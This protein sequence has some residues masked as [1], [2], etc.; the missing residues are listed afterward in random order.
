M[1]VKILDLS[2][3]N[4]NDES[5]IQTI[6]NLATI[7]Y[8]NDKAKNPEKLFTLLIE[9]GHESVLEFIRFPYITPTG[10]LKGYTIEESWR[11]QR[12]LLTYERWPHTNIDTVTEIHK[13]A[14]VTLR[15]KVPIFVDR[16]LV[17]H[18]QDSRI[19]LSRRYT[20]PEKVEFEYYYPYEDKVYREE[21]WNQDYQR[22][23]HKGNRPEIARITQPLATYTEYYVMRHFVG[24][25]NLYVERLSVYAQKETYELIKQEVELIIKEQPQFLGLLFYDV[26]NKS[27]ISLEKLLTSDLETDKV[28][29]DYG[30]K[31]YYAVF[32]TTKRC[33]VGKQL[34]PIESCNLHP[35]FKLYVD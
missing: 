25:R 16:Q 33:F 22:M 13:Q 35:T 18:R 24:A 15:V 32:D 29:L 2:K 1:E 34:K 9:K 20:K 26:R 4:L 17:R 28:L 19:E 8:G 7:S 27:F 5:R 23:L 10:E 14:L 3:S 11:N 12:G 30:N 6:A 31:H 21:E